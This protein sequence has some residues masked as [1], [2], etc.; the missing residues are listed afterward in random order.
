MEFIKETPEKWIFFVNQYS[1]SYPC[2]ETIIS[3]PTFLPSPTIPAW[4]CPTSLPPDPRA[5]TD[6][7]VSTMSSRTMDLSFTTKSLADPL[8]STACHTIRSPY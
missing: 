6:Q 8:A 2:F 3:I 4:P 1:I 7:S 5:S